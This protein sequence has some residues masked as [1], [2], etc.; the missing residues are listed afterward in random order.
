MPRF[1]LKKVIT[2]LG[3]AFI[4]FYLFTRPAQ[5]ADAVN[6]VFDGIMTG[7]NSLAVFVSSLAV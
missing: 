7:A 4:I 6:G 2:Y 3:L 1:N 5:A